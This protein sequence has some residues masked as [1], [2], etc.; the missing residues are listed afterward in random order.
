[1]LMLSKIFKL[2]YY[3]A[4]AV[5]DE[6]AA[7]GAF[8]ESL[9]VESLLA[10]CPAALAAAIESAIRVESAFAAAWSFALLPQDASETAATTAN[11]KTNF[12]IFIYKFR[13]S[14]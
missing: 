13:S 11:N 7:A 5:L 9:A 14:N 10:A 12:F 2:A 1:M 6:S 4:G 8:V 3:F